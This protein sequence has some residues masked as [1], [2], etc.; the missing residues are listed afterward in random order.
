MDISED[1]KYIATGERGRRPKIYIWDSE[2]MIEIG[3]LQNSMTSGI[4][5]IKFSADRSKLL[6][7]T[8][9]QYNTIYVFNISNFSLITTSRGDRSTILDACWINNNQFVTVGV[10]HFK[11]WEIKDGRLR[12]KKGLFGQGNKILICV[13]RNH[14]QVIVGTYGGTL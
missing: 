6:A 13:Q 11:K 10:K 14:G 1:K 3:H 7:I 5:V 8:C 12:D 4:R 2:T 9:D